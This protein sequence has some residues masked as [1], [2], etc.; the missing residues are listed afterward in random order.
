M[1]P[2]RNRPNQLRIISFSSEGVCWPD[3]AANHFLSF[4]LEAHPDPENRV[5]ARELPNLYWSMFPS[6][7]LDHRRYRMRDAQ[8][9]STCCSRGFVRL[10]SNDGEDDSSDLM[11]VLLA[12][13]L[14][15]GF[16][17]EI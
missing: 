4:T 17:R 11:Y 12:A 6:W 8:D 10:R 3:S 16:R 9:R 14:F 15:H 2:F 1:A 5:Q 13:L 7:Y